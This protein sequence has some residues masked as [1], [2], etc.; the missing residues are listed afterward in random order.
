MHNENTVNLFNEMVEKSQ[1]DIEANRATNRKIRDND[2]KTSGISKGIKWQTRFRNVAAFFIGVSIITIIYSGYKLVSDYITVEYIV[3]VGV[4][5]VVFVLAYWLFN[6]FKRKLEALS[7]IEGKL[8]EVA[9]KLK[10]EAELQMRPLNNLLLVKNY[11]TELFSKTLPLIQFDEAFDNKRLS[12]MISRFG[13]NVAAHEKDINQNT[14]HIQFGEIKGNP[15]FL[16]NFRKH[17]MGTK[18][19][20][21]SLTIHW[22]TRERDSNGNYQT[23][24]HSQTLYATVN[25]PCPYFNIHSQ[26]VYANE[27]ADKL[28]FSR[29]PSQIHELKPKRIAS[30]VKKR[31]KELQKLTE[32]SMKKGGT[33][34]ALGNNEF[35][36]LFYAKDRDNESQFRLLFTPLAQQ[37]MSKLIKDNCVG[38][39]DDFSFYK[40]KMINNLYPQHLGDVVQ[41]LNLSYLTD[42]DFD[43]IESKFIEYHN[44][45]FKHIYFAFAPLLAIPVYAQHQTHEHIYENLYESN[46]SFYHHEEAASCLPLKEV[47]PP[48]CNTVTMYKTSLISSNDEVDMVA[49]NAWGYRTVDRTDYVSVKGGDGYWHDVPVHW[50]EYIRVSRE[51]KMEVKT[52]GSQGF[53]PDD[54][55]SG[56]EDIGIIKARIMN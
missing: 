48:D 49:V 23:V 33:F 11:H 13:F 19:Y 9:K 43:K 16:R 24:N 10:G 50:S 53:S 22:T 32:T 35:D 8:L 6:K 29:Q 1:V 27:A 5:V 41:N 25:K 44:S 2:T 45:Y 40:S 21:G 30:K 7:K 17:R 39:G 3:S 51:T 26:L 38:F 54:R 18:D 47:T 52:K 20:K 31:S 42:I 28:S 14:R 36:A 37:E 34:T 56:Y 55:T 15:F 46:V 4:A 12:Q